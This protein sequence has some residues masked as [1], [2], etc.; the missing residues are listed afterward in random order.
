MNEWRIQWIIINF[1]FLQHFHQ[2]T[3]SRTG[4]TLKQVENFSISNFSRVL[5]AFYKITGSLL[6]CYYDTP[7]VYIASSSQRGKKISKM[8]KILTQ[9]LFVNNFHHIEYGMNENKKKVEIVEKLLEKVISRGD[10]KWKLLSQ[11]SG[12]FFVI[13]L[14]SRRRSENFFGSKIRWPKYSE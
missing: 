9:Q 10:W 13:Q 11:F 14:C 8:N 2:A 7:P 4:T 6:N 5:K 3:L 12:I 1:H